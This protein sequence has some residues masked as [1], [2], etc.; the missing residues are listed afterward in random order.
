MTPIQLARRYPEIVVGLL[1]TAALAWW[2]TIDRMAGMGAAPGTELGTLGWF[3]GSWVVM[4][5]AMM[6]PSLAPTL[7]AY[8]T[9]TRGRDPMRWVLFAAGY[10]LVWAAAGIVAYG[11]FELGKSLIGSELAWHRAGRWVSGGVLAAAAAYQFT[12]AKR[13]S[14][15]RCRGEL[16]TSPDKGALIMGVRSGGWCLGCSWALMAALFALGVMSITWMVV[17]AALVA[18]EK[19]GPWRSSARLAGATVL[20]LLAL[21]ILVAPHDVPGLVVPGSPAAM[22][23][24]MKA[25]G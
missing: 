22:H 3:T 9:V 13:A 21:G 14:L 23:G 18:L 17:I 12:P 25:M 19:S 16:R 15:T 7:S 11:A 4:M 5:A 20:A 6:L 8:A 10:L 24:M 2:W 1:A